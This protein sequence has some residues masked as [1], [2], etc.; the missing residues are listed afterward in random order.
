MQGP[1]ST[2]YQDWHLVL[3]SDLGGAGLA[4]VV[5]ATALALGL[6]LWGYRAER[7]RRVRVLLAGSR[8]LSVAAVL[9]LVLQPGIQQ[10]SVTRLP[11]H[12]V[13]LLDASRS[14]ALRERPDGPTRWERARALL[15]RSRGRI[16][17]WRR[18]RVVHH[19]TF[20]AALQPQAGGLAPGGRP[21]SPATRTQEALAE[22]AR[23]FK[24]KDLAA[25]LVISDGLDNGRLRRGGEADKQLSQLGFPVHTVWS[26]QRGIRDVS[27]AEIYADH[28]AF[29]RN[30]VKVEADVLVLGYSPP[31]L[32]VRLE[33]GGKLLARQLLRPAP[34]KARYRARLE[35]V[36]PKVGKYVYTISVPVQ[37]GEIL[38][39]NN[40]RSFVLKVIRDRIRVLQLCGRPSWDQRFLRRLLKRDPN[41][42]LISFFILRTPTDLTMV[43]SSELSLI[44]F[45]TEELFRKELGSFDLVLLQNFNYGPYGIG[46][47]LPDLRRYVERGGGLAM[48]GGDLSFSSGG[49]AGTALAGVLPVKLP[50]P[51]PDPA[52]L[53]SEE[54][55]R[56]RVTPRGRDH[57]ILQLGRDH[58]ETRQVLAELPP[59]A[60]ANLVLGA[61]PGATVLLSHPLLRD[62]SGQPMPVLATTE[63]GK[64]RT[65]ALTSDSSWH[66]AFLS[67]EAGGTRQAYDRFWRN[68]I[69]WLIRDPELKYLRV[70]A[71]QD[72]VRLGTPLR[73][74]IRAYAPDYSPAAGVQIRHSITPLSGGGKGLEG[75]ARSDAQGEVQLEYTPA[76]AG[77]YRVRASATLGGRDTAEEELVLVEPSGPEE[78]T[79]QATPDLLQ[80]LSRRTG[81]RYLGQPAELPQLS[82]REPRVLQVNWQR[83]VELWSRWWSLLLVV[84][85]LG[86][87]WALRRRFGYL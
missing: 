76:A 38:R 71:Q 15:R 66:W 86:A 61:A 20:G 3:L 22:L 35:F 48:L 9:G 31:R 45:P 32:E 56:P 62:A 41:V 87:E 23:R 64:G 28:F 84:L 52:R 51:D 53:L 40:R 34:G 63:V 78:R 21:D 33:S 24:G 55:F 26:G 50:P 29:V 36:P 67:V 17:A 72:Q 25:V 46:G 69:R 49:Y 10:R 83:D 70:I 73:A 6:V 58:A 65:L 27:V 44:P 4:L 30:A 60:G 77:A 75:S 47:Y 5:V 43:D 7:R 82:F 11:N 37:P 18:R 13:L 79:L 42:D 54:S 2:T 1:A 81:G 14:M 12:L 59:L 8:L 16:Q 57:P 80:R 39:R 19:Y 74:I 85:L 68:A